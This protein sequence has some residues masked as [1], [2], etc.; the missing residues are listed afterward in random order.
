VLEN[1][2]CIVMSY[3]QPACKELQLWLAG[4]NVDWRFGLSDYEIDVARNRNVKEFLERDVPAGKQYLLM[5]DD[6]MVPVRETNA[7]LAAPGEMVFCGHCS[8]EGVTAHLGDKNFTAAC[9]RASARLLQSFGPPWF[10]MGHSGD[11][12]Q[13]TYCEC[14]YFRDRANEVGFDG[15]M[16]GVVG[17][18][19]SC[20]LLPDGKDKWKMFFPF[21]FNY[22]EICQTQ[23]SGAQP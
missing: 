8:K 4:M 6:D 22:R 19:A 23:E 3:G 5:I 14:N 13:R 11:L 12:L 20:V 7:I 16:V 9:F 21:R 10:R 18:K 15:K 17:H 1:I 2:Q